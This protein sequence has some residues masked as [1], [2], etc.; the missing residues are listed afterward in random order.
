[1]GF[2]DFDWVGKA[3]KWTDNALGNAVAKVLPAAAVK[4]VAN[5]TKYIN[6][7]VTSPI[8]RTGAI[9]SRDAGTLFTALASDAYE[10]IFD[11]D[12]YL[13][14]LKRNNF[15]E[16]AVGKNILEQT[17]SSQILSPGGTRN[18]GTGYLPGG[19]ALARAEENVQNNR[20]RIGSHAF[21][22][23]RAGAYPLVKLGVIP[24]DGLVHRLISGTVDAFTAVKNPL[25][26]F[27]QIEAIRPAGASKSS[28]VATGGLR[29][30]DKDNFATYFNSLE[31]EVLDL[32]QELRANPRKMTPE[33]FT[34][35]Q[36]YGALTK[37]LQ[38][39]TTIYAKGPNNTEVRLQGYEPGDVYEFWKP[40]VEE[41]VRLQSNNIGLVDDVAPSLIRNN[42][43]Q[44]QATAEA[45]KWASELL[46]G[47]KT[48]RLTPAEI[49]RTVLNREGIQTANRL[50]DEL[51]KPGATTDDVWRIVD[52]GV[53]SLEPGFN[54]RN[55]GRSTL[56]A[57]RSG[58][59]YIIKNRAQRAGIRQFELLPEDTKIGFYDPEQ[60]AR[61]LDNMMGAFN[62]DYAKRN[63]WLSRFA[64]AVSG[65]KDDLFVYL[66]EFEREAIAGE[67]R[68][69][70]F[71][72][73]SD[74]GKAVIQELTSWTQSTADDV[75]IFTSNDMGQLVPMPWIAGDGNAPLRN[76]QLMSDGYYVISP[77]IMR[78]VIRRT[79]LVGQLLRKGEGVPV[80]GKGIDIA[81]GVQA[82][83]QGYMS[84]IW[85]PSRVAKI[86]HLIRVVTEEILRGMASG[87]FEHPM[88][89]ML[90]ILGRRGATDA[91]GNRIVGKI[92]NIVKMNT[93][94][95]KL[96]NELLDAQRYKQ[97]FD[98]GVDLVPEELKAIDN[99]PALEAQIDDLNAKI[100]A[101]FPEITNALIGPR[102]RGALASATGEYAPLYLRMMRR[103]T[104]KMMDK[105]VTGMKSGW[106]QGIA[107][108]LA[109]MFVNQDYRRIAKG[110]LLDKDTITIKGQTKTINQ[111]IA[112]GA[113]HPYTGQPLANNLDAVKLWMLDGSGREF[114]DQYFN[115]VANLK[116]EYTGDLYDTYTVASERVEAILNHDIA[117]VTGLDPV[118][119][120]VIETGKFENVRAVIKQSTGRGEVSPALKEYLSGTFFDAPHSPR[121]AKFYVK[122]V[123]GPDAVSANANVVKK[124]GDG[125]DRIYRF[126]FEEAY[127]RA[128]DF[129]SRSPSWKANYWLRM[130]ELMPLLSPDEAANLLGTARSAKLSPARLQRLELQ[131]KLA[132]GQGTV[133]AA[134]ILAKQYATKGTNDLLFNA[135]KRSVFGDQHRLTFPFFEA[136]REVTA[137]WL[138]LTAQNPRIIRNVAQ[139]AETAQEEGWFYT[140][141]YGDK[142]FEIPLTG[143]A[144]SA[145]VGE[146]NTIIKNF[147]VGL[148]AINIIGQGRP[149]FGPTIQ[150]AVD[151][152]LPPTA[153]YQAVREFF[154]P[155]GAPQLSE[156]S[157]LSAVFPPSLVQALAPVTASDTSVGEFMRFFLGNPDS[158]EYKKR[159]EIRSFQYLLNTSP[160]L[161]TGEDGIRRAYSEAEQMANRMTSVRG[162][163]AFFGPGAP[164]T[165]WVAQT[166]Y[167]NMEVAIL[168]DDLYQKEQQAVQ[169]GEPAYRAFERWL[170]MWGEAV[171]VYAGRVTKN[172]V[173]GLQSSREFQNWAKDNPDI[174]QDYPLVGGYLGPAGGEFSID[175]WSEQLGVGAKSIKTVQ[176]ASEQAQQSLGNYLYYKFVGSIP[177]E[178][179]NSL[180]ARVAKG[181]KIVEIEGMLPDWSRPGASSERAKEATRQ[182][183]AQL[184]S[185]T[186][187]KSLENLPI[188]GAL[189]EY[190][191]LRDEAIQQAI[192]STPG[193]TETNWATAPKIGRD[194]R[195]FLAE[196][197]APYVIGMSPDFRRVWEQVL[198][199]EFIVDEE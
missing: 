47:V 167:G 107:H 121:Y 76:S 105:Q 92:P 128:S 133:E 141:Q 111:H 85:K 177:P 86:S 152:I 160:E 169:N 158:I 149:G 97:A 3:Y 27:N 12:E 112:D 84:Q 90:A 20:A 40:K 30:A 100:N 130:E 106:V 145:M 109:D 166:K 186:E 110:A 174:L 118:L 43:Q 50:F 55:V 125:L 11:R 71:E 187:D 67:L 29:V 94:L 131:S 54:L 195:L 33:E 44:W 114:F 83:V 190:F 165:E 38:P 73:V 10:N 115:N 104:L 78:E 191:S 32:R 139:F 137:T 146:D 122:S 168:L 15:L 116:P 51:S 124:F 82:A 136:F 171:W 9:A 96:T 72:S 46:D 49:W 58:E 22:I 198:S 16:N 127:G 36:E 60:S 88:E 5:S 48:G 91:L 24:E 53:A 179:A 129:F 176:E 87:I 65:T 178:Y 151:K 61:N 68:R 188:V 120:E 95:D 28:R 157:A 80:L 4:P 62:F 31:R 52:E 37:E 6:N 79:G 180:D 81:E 1:M 98:D 42:Y 181:A 41:A 39:T 172:N 134:D 74:T 147:T 17:M 182:K 57:V 26:P 194:L 34:K 99:I 189:K 170:D 56:D 183:V 155:F 18:M 21:T 19:E 25:D 59:G 164:I 159:A 138:K 8:V 144:A 70:G 113:I 132:R 75:R 140:N 69:A 66:R 93:K 23:G 64:K 153:D 135:N 13:R 14:K 7:Y 77:D 197:V 143:A 161:Y 163:M 173:G 123:I 192:A 103:G 150:F 101:D 117:S 148:G 119:L 142:V 199:F 63:E 35:S 89:Q 175:A 108:E 196:Q 185:M 162:L 156:A 45:S 193:L 2:W 154:S 184:R 126:Y 102:S